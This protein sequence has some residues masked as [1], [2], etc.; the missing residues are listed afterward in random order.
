MLQF[1][2]GRSQHWFGWWLGTEQPTCPQLNQWWLSTL[3]HICICICMYVCMYVHMCMYTCMCVTRSQWHDLNS[4]TEFVPSDMHTVVFCFVLSRFYDWSLTCWPL[5]NTKVISQVLFFSISFFQLISLTLHVAYVPQNL[6]DKSTLVQVM[7]WC[8]Q[9]PSHY[10][11]QCWPRSTLGNLMIY[12]VPV[13]EP[14]R[15][16]VI[17]TITKP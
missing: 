15:L 14:W 2:L 7:A 9:A 6:N 3:I 8:R 11:N 4:L 17:S 12:P 13:K 10:L 16:W 1:E 5:R